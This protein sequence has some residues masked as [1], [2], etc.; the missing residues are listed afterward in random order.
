MKSMKGKLK[1]KMLIWALFF[2][3]CMTFIPSSECN[4]AKIKNIRMSCGSV[5]TFK[6]G[7]VLPKKI[8]TK[9]VKWKITKGKKNIRLVVSRNRRAAEFHA[10]KAGTAVVTLSYKGKKKQKYMITILS[11]ESKKKSDNND[12]YEYDE[13]G[14]DKD[15][16]EIVKLTGITATAPDHALEWNEE[17]TPEITVIPENARA[18]WG[19][20][21]VYRAYSDN[22]KV[23]EVSENGYRLKAVG[24]GTANITIKA[25]ECRYDSNSNDPANLID[26]GAYTTFTVT[27]SY[28]EYKAKYH[29]QIFP[30]HPEYVVTPGENGYFYYLKTDNPNA[31]TIV[32]GLV[33]NKNIEYH[34]C[35]S[36]IYPH[37]AG[38]EVLDLGCEKETRTTTFNG[39]SH[40]REYITSKVQGGY[41]LGFV[42]SYGVDT[43]GDYKFNIYEKNVDRLGTEK[44]NYEDPR[45]YDLA[46]TYNFKVESAQI[47]W[48]QE[49]DRI[50]K[51]IND[52]YM[53]NE[54]KSH[55]ALIC[56]N[57][58]HDGVVYEDK[59]ENR[60][61]WAKCG[62]AAWIIHCEYSYNS[63]LK[64]G[65]LTDVCCGIPARIGT[66]HGS[67]N[68]LCEV[69]KKLGADSAEL[70]YV[71]GV[72]KGGH[73]DSIIKYN[74]EVLYFNATP[75]GGKYN[76]WTGP[77]DNEVYVTYKM[78]DYSDPRFKADWE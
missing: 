25:F 33:N 41:I 42:T 52:D 51:E 18:S 16:R 35:L 62:F 4:A 59:A 56:R 75:N 68:V 6:A 50:I 26:T 47:A 10:K 54:E 44:G 76:Y 60:E 38:S 30:I 34:E 57:T 66:C 29:Y 17:F 1:C 39:V 27:V 77:C 11:N 23:V 58:Q 14:E 24:V 37:Y 55:L 67:N 5:E 32:R 2:T 65:T 46:Y 48:D 74:G 73:T 8:K 72:D 9:K 71:N 20:G 43:L 3:V 40:T 64:E 15:S 61:F 78:V 13:D 19:S 53:N 49:I 45:D 21:L 22:D 36:D 31:D 7:N 70:Y 12:Y 28:E 69:A 63:G